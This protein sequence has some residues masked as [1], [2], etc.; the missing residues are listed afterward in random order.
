MIH[1]HYQKKHAN[2]LFMQLSALCRKSDKYRRYYR[3]CIRASRQFD[4]AAALQY[5]DFRKGYHL[6]VMIKKK[7]T[8]RNLHTQRIVEPGGRFHNMN[9]E[10]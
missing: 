2:P 4:A 3:Y 8:A 1:R 9:Q 10:T 5:I 6:M 7:K